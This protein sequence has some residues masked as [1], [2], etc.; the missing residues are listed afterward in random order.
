VSWEEGKRLWVRS[1]GWSIG[2]VYF[3][4]GQMA[5]VV[6]GDVLELLEVEWDDLWVERDKLLVLDII[7]GLVRHDGDFWIGNPIKVS[8]QK[9]SKAF[10]TQA[11]VVDCVSDGIDLE[12]LPVAAASETQLAWQVAATGKW[13]I[14]A[15]SIDLQAWHLIHWH[16]FGRDDRFR[17]REW[18]EEGRTKERKRRK[19]RYC[20]SL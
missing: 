1:S 10:H 17:G 3:S 20:V 16:A 8:L 6:S 19:N 5:V 2:F 9:L 15:L 14:D 4:A 18:G 11:E 7:I 12:I 13:L